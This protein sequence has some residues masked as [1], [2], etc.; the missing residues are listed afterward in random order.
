MTDEPDLLLSLL[1]RW[2][3]GDRDALV[4]LLSELQPWLRSESRNMLRAKSLAAIES[5]DVVQTSMMRFLE[6]GPRFKPES[7]AQLR[8]LIRRIALN[9][10][11]DEQRRSSHRK[12]QHFDSLSGAS[13]SMSTFGPAGD[14]G[15]S[16]SSV[17]ERN[18]DQAWIA[19]A[20]QFL[21][22]EDRFLLLASE[23]DGMAWTKIA[24]ELDLPSADAARVRA[25][26]LKPR[27]ANILRQLLIGRTPETD[28]SAAK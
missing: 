26:R 1:S 2:Y 27:I 4:S 24:S 5:M 19:L 22:P 11:T 6:Y 28:S 8:A 16:P 13:Q 14:S 10:I 17:A 12:N 15:A 21:P 25:A 3:A 9:V 20:L 23:V 7:G 18:E